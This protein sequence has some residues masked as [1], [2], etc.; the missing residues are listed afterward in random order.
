MGQQVLNLFRTVEDDVHF[1]V[2]EPRGKRIEQHH[3]EAID[4]SKRSLF[5]PEPDI[6]YPNKNGDRSRHFCQFRCTY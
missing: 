1:R 3:A 6:Q 4:V 2:C 5:R